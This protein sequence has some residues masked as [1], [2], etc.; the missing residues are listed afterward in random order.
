MK[1]RGSSSEMLDSSWMVSAFP[2]AAAEP[3]V[4]PWNRVEMTKYGLRLD[5]TWQFQRQ[6]IASEPVQPKD[7][8]FNPH[9]ASPA[10]V[11]AN[12]PL[13]CHKHCGH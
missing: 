12:F 13:F 6:S 9:G 8:L 1:P 11:S 10:R 2:V 5:N 7:T 4:E 3:A